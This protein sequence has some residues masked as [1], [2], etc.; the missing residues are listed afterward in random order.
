MRK[1]AK[2]ASEMAELLRH[3]PEKVELREKTRK[4]DHLDFNERR[5]KYDL[6]PATMKEDA[7]EFVCLHSEVR[8]LASILSQHFNPQ[9]YHW[10]YNS[11]VPLDYVHRGWSGVI[12]RHHRNI[13]RVLRDFP[14]RFHLQAGWENQSYNIDEVYKRPDPAWANQLRE[15]SEKIL[16][17]LLALT[18]GS[19]LPLSEVV[20][21]K[22]AKRDDMATMRKV[23]K[24]K[25][26]SVKPDV[27]IRE[28]GISNQA[29]RAALRE[30]ETLG[31]Y[32]G[33]SKKRRGQN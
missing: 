16:M 27:L 7:T 29:G 18:E 26:K 19:S 12:Q 14:A 30:L 20:T 17:E 32:A 31:E 33:F 5:K 10:D 2:A 13:R 28:A 8:S 24:S 21:V 6:L 4:W 22:N 9:H 3:Y 23:I 15:S 11:G 1:A 25:G